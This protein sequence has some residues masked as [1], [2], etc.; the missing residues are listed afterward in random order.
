VAYDRGVDA[1]L[2]GIAA[3]LEDCLDL[4]RLLEIA[5]GE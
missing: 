3:A 4:D 5:H 1:A 2:D